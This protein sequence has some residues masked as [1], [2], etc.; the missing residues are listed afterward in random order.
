MAAVTWRRRRSTD[1]SDF[2]LTEEK[3]HF[4]YIY[5]GKSF[6]SESST[7]EDHSVSTVI[8][9]AVPLG[10]LPPSGAPTKNPRGQNCFFP[11]AVFYRSV[12][13]STISTALWS[14]RFSCVAVP[15]PTGVILSLAGQKTA[16]V[17]PPPSPFQRGGH[18]PPPFFLLLALL[19]F[20][21]NERKKSALFFPSEP[22]AGR[23][24][25]EDGWLVGGREDAMPPP[26]KFGRCAKF[27]LLFLCAGCNCPAAGQLGRVLFG[28][29][30]CTN[31]CA[32]S[33]TRRIGHPPFLCGKMCT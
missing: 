2:F 26:P 30:R 9:V 24:K 7:N 8:G 10:P 13:V 29:C 19:P 1:G 11:T 33:M 17:P 22:Y 18:P 20:P 21:P 12:R 15:T 28:A 4:L 6:V 31:V 27:G 32:M 3:F 23:R 14:V 5:L 25:K 16:T